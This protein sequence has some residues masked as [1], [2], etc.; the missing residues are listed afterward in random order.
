MSDLITDLGDNHS[1]FESPDE[2]KAT[3]AGFTAITPPS[4]AAILG[5]KHQKTHITTAN[6]AMAV[7][8]VLD[9]EIAASNQ[10][11]HRLPKTLSCSSG[12]SPI[13]T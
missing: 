7:G 3:D 12:Y 11:L 4:D 10:P 13:R 8:Q 1:Y 5:P 9:K 6:G 2:A